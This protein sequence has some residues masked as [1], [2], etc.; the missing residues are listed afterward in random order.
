LRY[1][2]E[3]SFGHI[4]YEQ[5]ITLAKVW[6]SAQRQEVLSRMHVTSCIAH[7][8][9]PLTHYNEIIE[10]LRDTEKPHSSFL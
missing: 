9:H 3:W 1:L 8:T 10:V 6:E 7:C 5:G 2:D 4:D